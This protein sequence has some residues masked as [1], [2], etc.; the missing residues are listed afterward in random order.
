MSKLVDHVLAWQDAPPA[1][2]EALFRA[3]LAAAEPLLRSACALFEGPDLDPAEAWHVASVALW[4]EA[5][6]WDRTMVPPERAAYLPASARKWLRRGIRNA[7]AKHL[8]HSRV[9]RAVPASRMTSL[10]LSDRESD[11]E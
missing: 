7:L 4:Q 11:D 9:V 1:Q 3:L 10:E 2:K 5:A 6:R 8:R